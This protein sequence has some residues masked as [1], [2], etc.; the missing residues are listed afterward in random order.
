MHKLS[1]VP[2]G[3]LSCAGPSSTKRQRERRLAKPSHRMGNVASLALRITKCAII[4]Q[5]GTTA[6]SNGLGSYDVCKLRNKITLGQS[7][8]I[9]VGKPHFARN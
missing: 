8:N 2:E 6:R 3:S 1:V 4:G 7:N 5:P 9:I